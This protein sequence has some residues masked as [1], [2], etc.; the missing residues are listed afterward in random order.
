MKIRMKTLAAGPDFLYQP[1]QD[2]DVP[3]NVALAW[4]KQGSAEPVRQERE[5]ATAEAPEQ[6]V[7]P[8]KARRRRKSSGN[9]G[10]T[11]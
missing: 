4:I 5:T 6:A 7:L 11:H 9:P 8:K 2:V 3:K 10:R 1:G